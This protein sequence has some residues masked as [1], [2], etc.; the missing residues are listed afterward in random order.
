M[1]GSSRKIAVNAVGVCEGKYRSF[2]LKLDIVLILNEHFRGH[3]EKL[4]SAELQGLNVERFR[5]PGLVLP[6]DEPLEHG[7]VS[8][9]LRVQDAA[10]VTCPLLDFHL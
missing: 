10:C 9:S 6:A 2:G 3:A 5:M 8:E 4:D 7:V 1:I